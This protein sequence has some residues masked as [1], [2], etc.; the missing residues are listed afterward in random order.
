M[1]GFLAGNT[2][3][4]AVS[5]QECGDGLEMGQLADCWLLPQPRK[6]QS[7][8]PVGESGQI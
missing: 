6:T 7:L 1:I 4:R 5:L 3:V 2:V 8:N